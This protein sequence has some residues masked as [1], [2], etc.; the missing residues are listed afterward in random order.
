MT[1]SPGSVQ[2]GTGS[3]NSVRSANESFSGYDSARDDRNKRLCGRFRIARGTGRTLRTA[4]SADLRLV[5][6]AAIRVRATTK[7]AENQGIRRL[8]I[9][10]KFGECDRGFT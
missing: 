7:N 9:T 6:S 10:R 1:L 5:L 4:D 2:T 3:S 8:Q